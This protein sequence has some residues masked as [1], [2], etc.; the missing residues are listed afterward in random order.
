MPAEATIRSDRRSPRWS[1][2]ALG[3][4]LALVGTA[5]PAVAAPA[6]VPQASPPA[7]SSPEPPAAT[8]HDVVE[9]TAVTVAVRVEPR[10]GHGPV[11]LAPADVTVREDGE[12]RRVVSLVR[13]AD[14]AD[15]GA[16]EPS[17]AAASAA[18]TEA[19][20]GPEETPPDA[21]APTRIAIYVDVPMASAVTLRSSL[22]RLRVLAGELTRLGEVE[23]AVADPD[24]VVELE[25]TRDAAQVRRVLHRLAS[26]GNALSGIERIR[27]PV[28]RGEEDVGRHRDLLL[29]RARE[30]ARFVRSRQTRLGVWAAS[31]PSLGR[32]RILFL[33]SGAYDEDPRDFYLDRLEAGSRSGSA[34][35]TLVREPVSQRTLLETDLRNLVHGSDDE[36]LGSD[37]A[38][39]GW[40]VFPVATADLGLESFGSA[41]E[42]GDSRWLA[43]ARGASERS[44]G[45]PPFLFT[46]PLSGWTAL[47]GPSGGEVLGTDRQVTRAVRAL[48]DVFL[49]TYER[50]GPPTGVTHRLE[51]EI[52]GSGL[53][54]HAPRVV[55]EGTPESV[56][57][58][59]AAR[60]LS[61]GEPAADLPVVLGVASEVRI[62]D[63]RELH[64]AVAVDVKALA[65]LMG[66]TF[67]SAVRL[68]VA[69][70]TPDGGVRVLQRLAAA[71]PGSALWRFD[72]TVDAPPDA[73]RL[74]LAVEEL[75]TGMR[76]GAVLGLRGGHGST[77][78]QPR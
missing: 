5:T 15:P 27:L 58:L 52:P 31:T 2:V 16:P 45:A 75:A 30:E 13:L 9:I 4:L 39:L 70:P 25:P 56:A 50:T 42:P 26:R 66:P 74:A 77:T 40:M 62:D 6:A 21:A 43:M 73:E 47:A 59:A 19:A 10:R 78:P 22:A 29:A 48:G 51:V 63:R 68:T 33:V 37:L 61:G 18:A 55:S 7:T 12:R 23:I 3:A 36:S 67:G 41:E 24:P 34:G 57:G 64:L 49:L 44:S 38:T 72:L 60:L 53:E 71:P 46:H 28:L 69:V 8:I 11:R 32:P 76:G 35:G 1:G 65:P 14:Q 17:A 20:P 54:V